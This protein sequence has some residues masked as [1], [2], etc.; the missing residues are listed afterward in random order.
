MQPRRCLAQICAQTAGRPLG[1]RGP[2]RPLRP[3]GIAARA[4]HP[5]AQRRR[6]RACPHTPYI[7]SLWYYAY[8]RF[9]AHRGCGSLLGKRPQ[10][11]RKGTL[12]VQR[13]FIE[14]KS[15]RARSLAESAVCKVRY[16]C[17]DHLTKP[18]KRM[19]PAASNKRGA[20]SVRACRG[21]ARRREAV[22]ALDAVFAKA[23]T[24][25]LEHRDGDGTRPKRARVLAVVVACAYVARAITAR[26]CMPHVRG[27][28]AAW[29]VRAACRLRH[30]MYTF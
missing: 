25:V 16:T 13:P 18:C 8:K 11:H 27:C 17:A 1:A 3:R 14:L 29:Q 21:G 5:R 30:P 22:G 2:R 6:A 10:G 23:L 20:Q 28:N 19:H 4:A 7:A 24:Q 15:W 26:S 9:V 12:S